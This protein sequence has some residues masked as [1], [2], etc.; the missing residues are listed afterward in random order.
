M[1]ESKTENSWRV[2]LQS[3]S[4]DIQL[5]HWDNETPGILEGFYYKCDGPMPCAAELE[6]ILRIS[7]GQLE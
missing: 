5:E 6:E 1:Q 3:A 2:S 7:Q 4:K